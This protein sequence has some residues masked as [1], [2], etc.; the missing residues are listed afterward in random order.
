MRLLAATFVLFVIWFNSPFD[1]YGT[2][3]WEDEKARL[4][5]FAIQLTQEWKGVGAILI[6]D[7][8]NGCPGEAKARAIRAKRYMVE[9]RGIPW[10][11]VFWRKEGY[12]SDI[13]TTLLT[14]PH[15]AYA[16]Y[17]FYEQRGPQVDGPMTGACRATLQKIRR[18]G[19]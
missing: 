7:K 3:E 17:P 18:S 2:I 6:F 10:N 14:I 5:N 11:R 9:H 12:A 4:D 13:T 15:G 19:W 16:P 1:Q 8:A